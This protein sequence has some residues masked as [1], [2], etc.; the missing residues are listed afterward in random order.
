MKRIFAKIYNFIEDRI[1]PYFLSKHMREIPIVSEDFYENWLLQKIEPI[2][3]DE[4]M[5]DT[6]KIE[7]LKSMIENYDPLEY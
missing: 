2:I 7:M 5:S 4:K 1:L 3:N 6:E